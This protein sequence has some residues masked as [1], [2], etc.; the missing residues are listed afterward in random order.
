METI[1]WS[2]SGDDAADFTITGGEL[3]FAT[4]PDYEAAADADNDNV[5]EV[6]VTA[7]DPSGLSD[8][9]DVTVTVT[10]TDENRAPG[11]PSQ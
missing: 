10:D 2:L 11:L 4:V 9:I 5:Y 3:A 7:T 8:S 6:T 1:T